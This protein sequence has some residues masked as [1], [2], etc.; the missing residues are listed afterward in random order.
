MC[1]GSSS[2]C[3]T[4]VHLSLRSQTDGRFSSGFSDRG[5]NSWFHQYGKVSSSRSCEATPD[6]YTTPPCLT[7]GMMYFFMKSSVRFMP[8]VTGH[9]PSKKFNFCLISPQNICPNVLGIIKI[10]WQ[11]IRAFEFFLVSNVFCLGTLPWIRFFAQSFLIVE[12]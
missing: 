11:M 10:F 9:T 4:H 3:I 12:P 1:L 5:Q 2:C 6:H 8:D 7:V